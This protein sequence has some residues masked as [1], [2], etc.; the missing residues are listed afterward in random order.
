MVFLEDY[1]MTIARYLVS[2]SDVWLNAPRRPLEASGTSGMKAAMNGSLNVSVLDGW[3]D[4]A[5]APELGW[6]IGQGEE[7]AA[8]DVQDEIERKALY[9][10]LEANVVP[11]FYARGRDGL[12]RE[13]IRKMKASIRV[14]GSRFNSHRM[15]M[16][17]AERAYLPALEN[18]ERYAGDGCERARDVARYLVRLRGEW[19]KVGVADVSPPARAII[20]AGET[21][22]VTARVRL[23]A[24]E[25][26]E[27][28]VQLYYGRIASTGGLEQTHHEEM[29]PRQ[30]TPEGAVE[31]GAIL[32]CA[33][34]GRLGY[35]V[36]VLPKH[37]GLIDS[38]QYGL[39]TWA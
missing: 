20:K 25:P 24:L 34:T 33:Q 4:E 6:A 19:D 39:L 21:L 12:P 36:R 5:Y 38:R 27:V 10:L 37:A 32:T 8:A 29:T 16:D 18:F 26:D 35:T 1:D 15:L 17:Y 2:G 13:W 7:Y 22:E 11:L 3:W 23:G 28:E 9:D 30:R 14:V 31:Y